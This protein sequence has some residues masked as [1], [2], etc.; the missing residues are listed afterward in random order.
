MPVQFAPSFP[1]TLNTLS[2]NE[3]TYQ[4]VL[5]KLSLLWDLEPGCNLQII[6]PTIAK[7]DRECKFSNSFL[8][9]L[10]SLKQSIYMM[11]TFLTG[12]VFHSVLMPLLILKI[13]E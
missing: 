12:F 1:Y 13:K 10:K 2:D 11:F 7:A 8:T 5:L 9:T 4:S 3:L 6:W